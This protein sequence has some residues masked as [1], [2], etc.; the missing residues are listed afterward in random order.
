MDESR[1]VLRLE[2]DGRWSA[3]ELGNALTS[4]S[5]LYNLRL[6]LELLREDIREWERYFPDFLDF[7]P[8]TRRRL[9]RHPYRT[10]FPFWQ[11]L[12]ALDDSY[13]SRLPELIAPE[14]RLMVRRIKY[15]SPGITDLTGLGAI[16]G[17]LKD[18][19][20]R[21]IERRDG[22]RSRE[23]SEE[24]AEL[25]NDRLRIENARSFVALTRDLGYSETEIRDLLR[26]VDRKQDTLANLIAER[27]LVGVSTPEGE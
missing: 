7:P 11:G 19:S 17:H 20:L 21:L 3:E 2:L 1:R 26:H 22:K 27:K 9:R 10:V 15:A 8:S 24:R 14:E 13:L 25:E 4:L 16:I 5:D 18:F 6:F 12:P 23:L